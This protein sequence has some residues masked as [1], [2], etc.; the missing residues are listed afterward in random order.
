MILDGL[1]EQSE[2]CGVVGYSSVPEVSSMNVSPDYETNPETKV[3][4]PLT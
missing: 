4:L 3:L 2:Y 1:S